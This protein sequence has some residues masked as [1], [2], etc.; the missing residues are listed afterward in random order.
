MFTIMMYDDVCAHSSSKDLHVY[1]E[2]D[3]LVLAP[4]QV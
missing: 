4:T 1:I 2:Q 3:L